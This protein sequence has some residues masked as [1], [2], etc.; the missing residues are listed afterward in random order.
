M[1]YR[2]GDLSLSSLFPFRRTIR[3]WFIPGGYR[4][5]GQGRESTLSFYFPFIA[6]GG[7][8]QGMTSYPLLRRGK[9]RE[10]RPPA[11]PKRIGSV[12]IN[13][14]QI[15]SFFFSS[16]AIERLG[17]IGREATRGKSC[18][19]E[20]ASFFFSTLRESVGEPAGECRPYWLF[21]CTFASY[22]REHLFRRVFRSIGNACLTEILCTESVVGSVGLFWYLLISK[23]Q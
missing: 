17:A 15:S 6:G 14:C 11:G 1:T 23:D 8:A 3:S 13:F 5:L 20:K 16:F 2:V 7:S 22:S 18:A 12:Y 19:R 9:P 21:L 10:L 4:P